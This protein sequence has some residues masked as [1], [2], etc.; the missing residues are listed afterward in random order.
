M[1]DDIRNSTSYSVL[2]YSGTKSSYRVLIRLFGA[3]S[4]MISNR[5]C[6]AG[7]PGPSLKLE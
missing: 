7:A 5:D 1:A 4:A 6:S 3:A 2:L